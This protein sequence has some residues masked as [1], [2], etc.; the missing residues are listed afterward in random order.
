VRSIP[1]AIEA[2]GTSPR[3]VFMAKGGQGAHHAEAAPQHHSLVR[4][5]DPV[6]PALA[7]DNVEYILERG[8][9]TLDGE[10]ELLRRHDIDAIV[11]KNSGGAATYAEIEADRLLGSEV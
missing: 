5:V 10:C 4:S 7:L 2:L 8:P 3:P 9:F 6:A 1:A 11:A